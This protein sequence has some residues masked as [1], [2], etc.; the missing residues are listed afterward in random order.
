MSDENNKDENIQN[1]NTDKAAESASAETPAASESE[2]PKTWRERIFS[3][4]TFYIVGTCLVCFSI[5]TVT[6]LILSDKQAKSSCDMAQEKLETLARASTSNLA[7]SIANFQSVVDAQSETIRELYASI[8]AV[9]ITLS[10]TTADLVE[11]KTGKKVQRRAQ[12]QFKSQEDDRAWQQMIDANI[13]AAEEW[14]KAHPDDKAAKPLTTDY[15]TQATER[16]LTGK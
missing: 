9:N 2:E 10:D 13:K 4:G 5:G 7:T 8:L 3:A 12:P 15:G 16:A 1:E 11:L 14:I 6:G